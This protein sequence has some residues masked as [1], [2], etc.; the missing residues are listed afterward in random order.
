MKKRIED[1]FTSSM[2]RIISIML[3]LSMT[4][5]GNGAF[6]FASS[7]EN[8]IKNREENRSSEPKNYYE[9]YYS[10]DHYEEIVLTEN[11][12]NED[13]SENDDS[14]SL[15]EE[16]SDGARETRPYEE[17]RPYGAD[18]ASESELDGARVTR[19]YGAD[20]ASE[21]EVDGARV[22]RPYDDGEEATESEIDLEVIASVSKIEEKL[23][24][25]TTHQHKICGQTGECTHGESPSS[26][27]SAHV[28]KNY[29]ELDLMWLHTE[30]VVS[31]EYYSYLAYDSGMGEGLVLEIPDN[32]T[33]YLCLNGHVWRGYFKGLGSNSKVVITDCKGTGNSGDISYTGE[34]SKFTNEF[35]INQ[36][37]GYP[38]F[39]DINVEVYGI[40][41]DGVEIESAVFYVLT[42]GN[43]SDDYGKETK[44]YFYNTKII[45]AYGYLNGTED[46]KR[47]NFIEISDRMF[48]GELTF[49]KVTL[50]SK[51]P[52]EEQPQAY[53]PSFITI[54]NP[55][56]VFNIKNTNFTSFKKYDD[57]FIYLEQG[58]MNFYGTNR[59]QGIENRTSSFGYGREATQFIFISQGS[60]FN[61]SDGETIIENCDLFSE[62]LIH[63]DGDMLIAKGATLKIRNNTLQDFNYTLTDL[64]SVHMAF[65][66]NNKN[67]RRTKRVFGWDEYSA[68]Y[69]WKY[70]D[71][72]VTTGTCSFLGNL[73]I[74]NNLISGSNGHPTTHSPGTV[75]AHVNHDVV[76]LGE[77]KSIK[78]GSGSII[79]KDNTIE[80]IYGQEDY[81]YTLL[82]ET[83][84]DSTPI[85]IQ[86]EGTK[87]NK[88]NYIEGITFINSNEGRGIILENW[89]ENAEARKSWKNKLIADLHRITVPYDK[90]IRVC[91]DDNKLRVTD[92]FEE[93]F[94]KACGLPIETACNHDIAHTSSHFEDI[95]Y[96]ALRENDP[97]E[98]GKA[99]YL[100]KDMDITYETFT[101][102]E[103][104]PGIQFA[105]K[106][107]IC[108]N[109]FRL[110]YAYFWRSG[111]GNQQVYI[112]NCSENEGTISTGKSGSYE[113]QTSLPMFRNN[114]DYFVY[115]V[116]R[117]IQ[118]KTRRLSNS[119]Y[120]E[121]AIRAEMHN[122]IVS[123]ENTDD[124]VESLMV[125]NTY[126]CIA[127]FSNVTFENF[128]NMLNLY[129]TGDNLTYP[130]LNM[131]NCTIRNNHIRSSLIS[132]GDSIFHMEDCVIESNTTGI[133]NDLLDFTSRGSISL[134][135][136]VIRN[137]NVGNSVLRGYAELDNVKISENNAKNILYGDS[138]YGYGSLKANAINIS[139][140][141]V[142]N[143]VIDL[144]HNMSFA[145]ESYIKDNTITDGYNMISIG[146]G[147]TLTVKEGGTLDLSN[148]NCKNHILQAVDQ[149]NDYRSHRISIVIEKNATLNIHDNLVT[150]YDKNN[151]DMICL[152]NKMY[153]YGNLNITNNKASNLKTSDLDSVILTSLYVAGKGT[154]IYLGNGKVTIDTIEGENTSAQGMNR[155]GLYSVKQRF[156]RQSSGTTFNIEN[157]FEK[158]ALSS[159]KGNIIIPYNFPLDESYAVNSFEVATY[160]DPDY[161]ICKGQV[162]D[163]WIGPIEHK[164]K[165]CGTEEDKTCSH[166]NLHISSHTKIVEYEILAD[167]LT[168]LVPGHGYHLVASSSTTINREFHI[169]G[170]PTSE[171]VYICL[172]GYSL[173]NVS[174]VGENS[175]SK[176]YIS[177]CYDEEAAVWQNES[178]LYLFDRV[179]SYIY[180][181]GEK[182]DFYTKGISLR[183]GS[184][185]EDV[186]QPF[187]AYNASFKSVTGYMHTSD[188]GIFYQENTR[189]VATFSYCSFEKYNAKK[190]FHNITTIGSREYLK[191]YNSYMADNII[192]VENDAIIKDALIDNI[193]GKV[194][195]EN[196]V[197]KDNVIR[198][199]TSV[200]FN[201]GG[202]VAFNIS[203]VSIINNTGMGSIFSDSGRGTINIKDVVVTGNDT[204]KLLYILKDDSGE[205]GAEI[206][207][208]NLQVTNNK[209]ST[210]FDVKEGKVTVKDTIIKENEAA[211]LLVNDDSSTEF[212]NTN[213][214]NNRFDNKFILSQGDHSRLSMD[215]IKI[216]S[217]SLTTT[218]YIGGF[219]AI[220]AGDLTVTNT[221]IYSNDIGKGTALFNLY[222]SQT[223]ISSV[224]VYNNMNGD[225]FYIEGAVNL[226]IDG[227]SVKNQSMS[228]II[229]A[230]P[231]LAEDGNIG[232]VIVATAFN[233]ERNRITGDSINTPQYSGILLRDTTLTFCGENTI[234]DNV[235]QGTQKIRSIVSLKNN[236][237]EFAIRRGGTLTIASNSVTNYSLIELAG[238]NNSINV[239]DGAEL[240]IKD[241]KQNCTDRTTET[242]KFLSAL[243]LSDGTNI[244][245]NVNGNLTIK[246]NFIKN[247][248][249]GTNE[250]V[251][252]T[253]A[254][255]ETGSTFNIGN[256]KIYIEK[257]KV[258]SGVAAEYNRFGLYAEHESFMTQL[259]GTAF[260]T[261]NYIGD[262]AL[263]A[264][265]GRVMATNNFVLDDSVARASF[266]AANYN[267][268]LYEALKGEN[269]DVIIRKV[270]EHKHKICGTDTNVDCNHDNAHLSTHSTVIRYENFADNLTELLDGHGYYLFDDTSEDN[271]SRTFTIRGTVYICLNG[272]ALR[273]VNFV[274]NGANSKIYVCNCTSEVGS[275]MQ[276]A[277]DYMFDTV[278]LYL[279]GIGREINLYTRRC[280]YQNGTDIYVYN[281]ALSSVAGYTLTSSNRAIFEKGNSV[282]SKTLLT[283]VSIKGY[284]TTGM[285]S[286]SST[287]SAKST[288]EIYDSVMSNNNISGNALVKNDS[289]FT[290][291]YNVRFENNTPTSGG[292]LISQASSGGETN[293]SSISVIN[294]RNGSSRN[295][296][297]F[298]VTSNGTLNISTSSI[299]NN[300]VDRVINSSGRLNVSG[301]QFKDNNIG[302]ALLYGNG[303]SNIKDSEFVNN[304]LEYTSESG[305]Q[306][307]S[308]GSSGN[309][310]FKNIIF[311]SN[312]SNRNALFRNMGKLEIDT[313]IAENNSTND[314][315]FRCYQANAETKV[316]RATVSNN[317]LPNGLSYIELQ[318]TSITIED[319]HIANNSI[320]NHLLYNARGVTTYRN[321]NIFNHSGN[322]LINNGSTG[323]L[324][325][326]T[327][328]ENCKIAENTA[329]QRMIYSNDGYLNLTNVEIY[330][331]TSTSQLMYF[332]SNTRPTMNK[333]DINNNTC[334]QVIYTYQSYITMT[335]SNITNN[336]NTMSNFTIEISRSSITLNGNNNII[337]NTNATRII[338]MSGTNASATS[339]ILLQSGAT[340]NI[341]SNSVTNN[342]IM[343]VAN[344]SSVTVSE[345]ANFNIVGNTITVDTN[346]ALN[347]ISAL[348]FTG[349]NA[350]IFANGNF[351]IKDNYYRE[352][353][354]YPNQVS[355]IWV[356]SSV[357]TFRI[358]NN[359][360]YIE[361]LKPYDDATL[362]R[363]IYGIYSNKQSLITQTTGTTFNEDNYFEAVALSVG[364]GILMANNS[365]TKD[366]KV[367]EKSFIAA[368]YSNAEFRAYKGMNNNVVIGVRKII[369]DF[370]VPEGKELINDK[371]YPSYISIGGDTSPTIKK[372]TFKVAGYTFVGW[373]LERKE[374][375]S[376]NTVDARDGGEF[377]AAFGTDELNQVWTLYALWGG[378]VHKIC[379]TASGSECDHDNVHLPAHTKVIKYQELTSDMTILEAG[380]GYY[381]TESS[382]PTRNRILTVQ[383]PTPLIPETSWDINNDG[384]YVCLNGYTLYNVQFK[385]EGTPARVCVCNCSSDEAMLTRNPDVS[386]SLE[387]GLFEHIGASIYGTGAKINLKTEVAINRGGGAHSQKVEV[388][389]AHF[390]P[391]D[392]YQ[393]TGDFFAIVHQGGGGHTATISNS[394]FEGY[395]TTHLLSNNY[396]DSDYAPSTFGLYN[397]KIIGN[398]IINDTN[399]KGLIYNNGGYFY[400]ENVAFENNIISNS[401]CGIY[402]TENSSVAGSINISSVSIINTNIGST[403]AGD[404]IR[405]TRG[406]IN[407]TK[408]YIENN[409][410]NNLLNETGGRVNLYE[411]DINDNT[412]NNSLLKS[413]DGGTLTVKNSKIYNNTI[414][415]HVIHNGADDTDPRGG[416][417]YIENVEIYNHTI[418]GTANSSIIKSDEWTSANSINFSG[419]NYIHDNIAYHIV[420]SKSNNANFENGTTVFENNTSKYLLNIQNYNLNILATATVSAINNTIE[421]INDTQGVVHL[422][423]T[424]SGRNPMANLY[425][426][427][428]VVNNSFVGAGSITP[429]RVDYTPAAVFLGATSKINLGNG[430]F[431]VYGNTIDNNTHRFNKMY[432]LFSKMTAGNF[433]T[434]LSGTSFN[435]NNFVDGIGFISGKGSIMTGFTKDNSV[436]EK[437]FIA[438]TYSAVFSDGADYKAYKGNSNNVVIG[439]RK[440]NFNFNAPEGKTVVNDHN[441]PTSLNVGGKTSVTID[442][443]TFVLEGKK[444]VGW[445]TTSTARVASVVD[446]GSFET[447]FGTD[448]IS[449]SW[450]LYAIWGDNTMHIHKICGTATD[451]ECDHDNVHLP[452]H[453]D[454]LNYEPL[455]NYLTGDTII[456]LE[457]GKGY[458][459]TEDT[460]ATKNLRLMIP[461]IILPSD[462]PNRDNPYLKDIAVFICLNGHTLNNTQFVTEDGDQKSQV[463]IC[464]C[465]DEEATITKNPDPDTSWMAP[466]MF[467]HIGARLYGTGNRIN[468][469]TELIFNIVGTGKLE[470]YNVHISPADGWTYTGSQALINSVAG[471]HTATISNTTIEG[472]TVKSF[473]DN[474][475]SLTEHPKISIYD[476]YIKN[477]TITRGSS[478]NYLLR[479]LG[480][481]LVMEN[482]IFEN[483]NLDSST[484][485]IYQ[486]NEGSEIYISS[487]SF[488]NT[489]AGGTAAGNLIECAGGVINATKSYISNNN[490]SKLLNCVQGITN[491]S[492]SL[493]YNNSSEDELIKTNNGSTLI[494]KGSNKIY[495]NTSQR[496][497]DADRGNVNLV[498]SDTLI[499]EN[500]AKWQ[501][502]KVMDADLNIDNSSS[503]SVLN[504]TTSR[505]SGDTSAIVNIGSSDTSHTSTISANGNL[506]I[507][508]NKILVD[509][510]YDPTD[511]NSSPAGLYTGER[512]QVYMGNGYIKIYGNTI[513]DDSKKFNKLYQWYI[514][515]TSG[516]VYQMS[517]TTFN[518]NTFINGIGLQNG[519][520][521]I[522][523]NGNFTK[524]NEVA[525]KSFI[526]ATYNEH[527]T[528]GADFRAY[529]G[530]DN[531]VVIGVIKDRITI[532]YN[533]S[534]PSSVNSEYK[535]ELTSVLKK[536]T[537]STLIRT[538]GTIS[539]IDNPYSID[540]YSFKGWSLTPVSRL[541]ADEYILDSTY[542]P[543]KK[544]TYDAILSAHPSKTINLYAVWV[545]STYSVTL[546]INDERAGNGTGRGTFSE[547]SSVTKTISMRYDSTFEEVSGGVSPLIPTTGNRRGY[548]YA[549][550]F[551]KTKDIPVKDRATWSI[552]H[553]EDVMTNKSIYRVLGN[554]ELYANWIN[555]EYNLDLY[556]SDQTW[557]DSRY[558]NETETVKV[559]YDD[560]IYLTDYVIPK[561]KARDA[562]AMIFDYWSL[563]NNGDVNYKEILDLEED[564]YNSHKVTYKIANRWNYTSDKKAAAI[565]EPKGTT[566]IFDAGEKYGFED[567]GGSYHRYEKREM[568]YGRNIG[569]TFDS[570][571]RVI[572]DPYR[573]GYNF[574]YWYLATDSNIVKITSDMSWLYPSKA[575]VS[576][577]ASYSAISYK[578]RYDKNSDIVT[579]MTGKS[580]IPEATHTYDVNYTTYENPW[581][582]YRLTFKYWQV[583]NYYDTGTMS[584]RVA[585]FSEGQMI[586]NLGVVDGETITI[587]AVWD[588]GEEHYHKLCGEAS[589]SVCTH[590][591]IAGH[592][593]SYGYKKLHN[594]TNLTVGGYY[595]VAEDMDVGNITVTPTATLS[596]CLNG[597]NLSGI[598]FGASHYPVYITNCKNNQASISHNA[599]DVPTDNI[600]TNAGMYEGDTYI[601]TPYK[602]SIVVKSDAFIN[603][604]GAYTINV[605]NVEFNQISAT[606]IS[607]NNI[608]LNS[609]AKLNAENATFKGL[610]AINNIYLVSS[611]MKLKNVDLKE[612]SSS[613]D[614]IRVDNSTFDILGNNNIEN[615]EVTR[616]E[617][618]FQGIL[619]L[620]NDN[621][622]M[623]IYGNL[624]V[625][626]NK[627]LGTVSPNNTIAA[628]NNYSSTARINIGN[629]EIV[630]KD[631]TQENNSN[632]NTHMF[633]LYSVK[634]DGLIYQLDST[635][636]NDNNYIEDIAFGS[637]AG[638]SVVGTIVAANNFTESNEVAEKSFKAST[639]SNIDFRA[640]K[641][642]SDSVVIGIRKVYFDYNVPAGQSLTGDKIATINV[643]GKTRI[644]LPEVTMHTDEYEFMGWSYTRQIPDPTSTVA[645]SIDV[646]NGGTLDMPITDNAKTLYAVWFKDCIVINYNPST[647]SSVHSEYKNELTS[648]LKKATVSV[649]LKTKGTISI[650][651]SPYTIDGYT[652][653]GWALTPVGR[654]EADSYVLNATYQPNNIVTYGDMLDA[655]PSRTVN[656]YAVW[657]RNAYKVTIH[658]NDAR[659]GNGTTTG[660]LNGLTTV[661]KTFDMRYDSTFEEVGGSGAVGASSAS[662]LLPT[663]GSRVGYAFNGEWTKTQDI[664]IEDRASWSETHYDDVYKNN[665]VYRRTA[666]LELYANW[667]NKKYTV[668]LHANDDREG[669]GNTRGSIIA[670]VIATESY[671][672]YYDA[673]MSFIPTAGTRIGYTYGGV[674]LAKVLIKNRKKAPTV[675]TITTLY[676]YESDRELYVNWINNEFKLTIDLNGGRAGSFKS[677]D[678]LVA[679]YDAVYPFK[680]HEG[681]SSIYDKVI[682]M[683]VRPH[684]EF[685]FFVEDV[686]RNV[687]TWSD[688]LTKPEHD[689]L[690]SLYAVGEN[691]C[692]LTSDQKIVA[693]FSP[694]KFD[695]KL[696]GNGGTFDKKPTMMLNVPY[697]YER[698]YASSSYVIPDP[699][700]PGFKFIGWQKNGSPDIIESKD[701]YNTDWFMY[702]AGESEHT[703]KAT[704]SEISYNI[705]YAM[706]N[707]PNGGTGT[708]PA[709]ISNV[710]FTEIV[711]IESGS[712]N[713]SDKRE[714]LGWTVSNGYKRGT[715]I[716]KNSLPYGT[717]GLGSMD[718]E[719][720][721]LEAT[722]AA[723]TISGDR[724]RG[725]DGPGGGNGGGGGGGRIN[726]GGSTGY[727]HYDLIGWSYYAF[728]PT[729]Y[730]HTKLL[731]GLYKLRYKDNEQRYYGFENGYMVTGFYNFYG[732]TYYFN[733]NPHLAEYGAMVFGEVTLNGILFVMNYQLGELGAIGTTSPNENDFTSQWVVSWFDD[734]LS[735]SRFLVVNDGK[736]ALELQGPIVLDGVTYVFDDHGIMQK[737]LIEYRENYYY[738]I[739]EGHFEGAVYPSALPVD[740]V[741]LEFVR[742]EGGRLMNPENLQYVT[743][744]KPKLIEGLIG[745]QYAKVA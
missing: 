704:Y 701:L 636:F 130:K 164:H 68:S 31:G 427:L 71:I 534:T 529:K 688:L 13:E 61:I 349:T 160:K 166:D 163:V 171:P 70:Q 388:Y 459:L 735:G 492:D 645:P 722:F 743:S 57:Y 514:Q 659:E 566:V 188:E 708:L 279:Y 491:I 208:T 668:T 355:G 313:L 660:S 300:R 207:Y 462:Y 254:V 424:V 157:R 205:S 423:Y 252:S 460:D 189:Q 249:I 179:S 16:E 624:Y 559:Y 720:I 685:H 681:A 717:S 425:G 684:S 81:I 2:K 372:A 74:T 90:D 146:Y 379:G 69:R 471:T 333:T 38:M 711:L 584:Y 201:T 637:A 10:E 307:I 312:S 110:N 741:I 497:I 330:D 510:S 25:V 480:A 691:I 23:L 411:V 227:M 269:S 398:N 371:N 228:C 168:E 310:I 20:E 268:N 538:K 89:S 216:A 193:G 442:P 290:T 225:L 598:S 714:F 124:E 114:I 46:N 111:A 567:E 485:G 280:A 729:T 585:T 184:T 652:F 345:N 712:F 653:K 610:E 270:A 549:G 738:L 123:P 47:T 18:E 45:K 128:E 731:N 530:D 665:S 140:N 507:I 224:N 397:S 543:K 434:Q 132:I 628:I 570:V 456:K 692:T 710:K 296:Y 506:N 613:T 401:N 516:G 707:I 449:Q 341:A 675:A 299:I 369:F 400:I 241:N 705:N 698:G 502:V 464:N 541:D 391:V 236:N 220:S 671:P 450:T 370:N 151:A 246:N 627:S 98:D 155:Y 112:C 334:T 28:L 48:K 96:V 15:I 706:T 169:A 263:A 466:H 278:N 374:P 289:G 594:D 525:E 658:A 412:A 19:P 103:P 451:S 503:L 392:G 99:Y 382:D 215:E 725:G 348:S 745:I 542:Q 129:S 135:N 105:G 383:S 399:K 582:N 94:H 564:D 639:F 49:E 234:Y 93:H 586:N 403:A 649:L 260:N 522:V 389:N 294:T 635:T 281:A 108:L 494:F 493:I 323:S 41:P 599:N 589:T 32:V 408:L 472:F 581:D 33:L 194:V 8:I 524:S 634:T 481:T 601:M 245:A 235:F 202:N 622:T 499:Y 676:N 508:D 429:D 149:R 86:E 732:H 576:I 3:V 453:T 88:D 304:V 404:L 463:F 441:Y 385:A 555:N 376:T 568:I 569:K 545:R 689:N 615:N 308:N 84:D 458:Y 377:N 287:V 678:E 580:S 432:Q 662:P 359:R 669:N 337:R 513:D 282:H 80:N 620:Q 703:L 314:S 604:N 92:Y 679:Y 298:S 117:P 357:R 390:S 619:T 102:S 273:N 12:D 109:G 63:Q 141:T 672:I 186:P 301:C 486:R 27:E 553:P 484:N 172:N 139:S 83:V 623:N 467:S 694:A 512:S 319:S 470:T 182:I 256:G 58:T 97:F 430:V 728:D 715:F 642:E 697:A 159:G 67:Y 693:W 489:N 133:D 248:Y 292:Y 531:D 496:I 219:I 17:T 474:S 625:R 148:N 291:I 520:G 54:D 14:K 153:L 558:T 322:Y 737:G 181:V 641:G 515:N 435:E 554:S 609:N 120:K 426:N 244:L 239:Q 657:T 682:D 243:L 106:I 661:T 7:V 351:T 617:G 331:N 680:W 621:P 488:I 614:C 511:I 221:N 438:A 177:N 365:F 393:N 77:G 476:T 242:G 461:T 237:S 266:I 574:K 122:V 59:V 528:D 214:T 320:T 673:T 644:D 402:Q 573:L 196:V 544:L 521:T 439:V 311:K 366:S 415:E 626:N 144:T 204:D 603:L 118:L 176:V 222:Y 455:S 647:P 275:I 328:L 602:D 127:T 175:Y 607:S 557:E 332:T 79:L 419:Y 360:L 709:S 421:R 119:I 321:V 630:V 150:N 297:I 22:T 616:S 548:T 223:D 588:V 469:K 115:S 436:A 78:I 183:I 440:I 734:Q 535:N 718:G 342:Q 444:F 162:N 56:Y 517:G 608:W 437:S 638:S 364:A 72:D 338:N 539:I 101:N 373:T 523:V 431:N 667:I 100:T 352:I 699:S 362:G 540:G 384:V 563:E 363:D 152:D 640:Y 596:I 116:H 134:K 212:V 42:E 727:W 9:M 174:F 482:V 443:A 428:Y 683:P 686:N 306:V 730:R 358:G 396:D 405:C 457:A 187:E 240:I 477:N 82:S 185:G 375:Y 326:T 611:S 418:T 264:G 395:T 91:V 595:Y 501:V 73:E 277:N 198:Q 465:S 343:A 633:G 587:K 504:N 651:E 527:F 361:K 36:Y 572:K 272:H 420:Y 618:D 211:T 35:F 265:T 509:A 285:F 303:N 353:V 178:S 329:T 317:T 533:P 26:R 381:L 579:L 490:V 259:S 180:G 60:A 6:T 479:N 232:N 29:T 483:N 158:V 288:L 736:R 206:N 407:A 666:E 446:G 173:N 167:D 76:Y 126:N 562:N 64:R 271:G 378:H 52:D 302:T 583:D 719:I 721:I 213:I 723:E 433:I 356:N 532:N 233:V 113:E 468:L 125:D 406:V 454:V 316:K 578:V 39:Y 137:N 261:E 414:A 347:N 606:N 546:H 309:M 62:R 593:E 702:G 663:N 380:K 267:D 592:R 537:S 498:N 200:V 631:N 495:S 739:Q 452:A 251:V 550:E 536:S 195:L 170:T 409:N 284:T 210:L 257:Y 295:G 350:D 191:V 197:I 34:K 262:V 547:I 37:H 315:M 422:G 565:F 53:N 5:T 475:S 339:T 664:R 632:I 24:G 55:Q 700:Y 571:T 552:V 104:Y 250:L 138:I 386:G 447:L 354:N 44:A 335:D 590:T 526:A 340:L 147:G 597:H 724:P 654:V 605:Y 473:I 30:G 226:Q 367:A 394:T 253:F 696:D 136:C 643:A 413:S 143:N 87:F 670:G 11:L 518:E 51:E 445:A 40:E 650:I 238:N 561:G 229:F 556:V 121:D 387:S 255:G 713:V 487:V 145:S 199:G 591:L 190:M 600:N 575:T 716:N 344:Y 368:T 551:T 21:S 336:T 305:A 646:V 416:Y 276:N 318:N 231:D 131:Y 740:G 478:D 505:E 203:S 648:A 690:H 733:E 43:E 154:D 325:G 744:M 674:T 107:Y 327:T 656:L 50:T 161:V 677:G 142:R 324:G 687:A 66:G 95:E 85:F 218:S 4:L 230:K 258:T 247:D 286:N 1:F 519:T 283:K 410:V 612:S 75:Y 346:L 577:I 742:D 293:V 192:G 65:I 417:L 274:G 726:G 209:F 560:Y 695:V 217:N 500:T 165:I 629:G 156:M 655:H 448:D